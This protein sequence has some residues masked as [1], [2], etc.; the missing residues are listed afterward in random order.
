MSTPPFSIPSSFSLGTFTF[1]PRPELR[2]VLESTL[3]NPSG[4]PP[5]E[6]FDRVSWLYFKNY[7][8]P[9]LTRVFR[10]PN[11]RLDIYVSPN[12]LVYYLLIE[13]F[14][15]KTY[16]FGVSEDGKVFVNRVP[17]PPVAY[18]DVWVKLEKNIRI[19][20][21]EDIQ[22]Y[23]DLGFDID[24]ADR[25]E[26][27]IE[28]KARYRI[29]G[30]LILQVREW[31]GIPDL[32]EQAQM[33]TERLLLDLLNRILIDNGLSP[34]GIGE[35]DATIMLHFSAPPRTGGRYA[36]RLRGLIRRGLAEIYGENAVYIT[37]TGAIGFSED[38]EFRG[39]Y[40]RVSAIRD[41]R[42]PIPHNP[43]LDLCIMLY[44]N[45]KTPIYEETFDKVWEAY[46]RASFTDMQFTLGNHHI[47]LYNI[48]S[49][50]FTYRPRRQ[51]LTLDEI[52]ITIRNPRTFLVTPQSRVELLHP[53]HG[54]KTV[55]FAGTYIARFEHVNVAPI[56]PSER[57][58][59]ILRNL[60]V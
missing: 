8:K 2:A 13:K 26:V 50:S 31:T 39:C 12:Y 17:T 32:S 60:K 27:V 34:T 6:L 53:E 15:P 20:P 55:R 9:K 3:S 48:K 46:E 56:F 1:E 5:I 14:G 45:S 41:I 24:L 7:V 44:C 43:S 52:A 23:N 4:V 29:Q 22:I 28:K 11:S 21:V 42:R 49:L 47:K 58:R 30:D 59:V 57:N 35:R 37:E 16:L 18:Y 40:I 33:Y 54:L 10:S 36:E 38:N 25:E 51:P 19:A